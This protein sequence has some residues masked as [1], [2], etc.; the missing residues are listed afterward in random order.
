MGAALAEAG[1]ALPPPG[2]M[3]V[4]GLG[5]GVA[6][7]EPTRIPTRGAAAGVAA[8]RAFDQDAPERDTD[9]TVAEGE[10]DIPF[11]LTVE[12]ARTRRSAVP[13]VVAVVVAAVG[14]AIAALLLGAGSGASVGV[15]SLVGLQQDEALIRAADAGVDI[16]VVEERRSDDPAGLVMEQDPAPGEFIAEG[17]EIQVVVSRGPPPV[18]LPDVTGKP[19]AEAQPLL[20]AAGFVVVV[21]RRFD[22]NVVRD[23]TLGTEPAGG[24][25]APRESQVKLI[26][27]DGPAPVPVPDVAGGSYEAAAEALAAKRL[28]AVRAEDFSDTVPAGTVIGT[29]PGAGQPAPRDSEVRVIVSKGPELVAVPNVVGSTVEAASEALA[30]VGLT[31]DVQNYGPGKRVRAQDPSAGAQVPKGSKVTLFL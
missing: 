7:V 14:I 25:T 20:E 31:P 17:S 22:E 12:P 24:G 29:D 15:P 6:D 3:P 11:A 21:E 2:P 19:L 30:A 16:E 4:A 8:G 9:A 10:P 1:R 13:V 27:S 18:P 5:E 28:V 23:I 26:V